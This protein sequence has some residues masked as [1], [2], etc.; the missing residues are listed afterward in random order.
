MS[1]E[2]KYWPFRYS[3][4]DCYKKYYKRDQKRYQRHLEKYEAKQNQTDD[5]N[6]KRR[7]V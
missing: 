3:C 5:E 7:K 6:S 1:Q 2:D 4:Y